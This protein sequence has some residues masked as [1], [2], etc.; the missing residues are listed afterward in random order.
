MSDASITF[1]DR[2]SPPHIATLIIMCSLSALTMN[3]FLPSLPNMTAYFETEYRVM[4][5]SVALYLGVNAALQLFIG[6]LSDQIG[7][8]PVVLG[9]FVLFLLATLGCIFAPNATV[10]LV[11]RMCQ[12]VVSVGLVLS[13]AIIRDIHSQ[14]SAASMIGYVTMGMAVAPMVSPAI[15]GALDAV[16][17]W[18]GSFWLLFVRGEHRSPRGRKTGHR[19]VPVRCG[20]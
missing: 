4:Q 11:F 10:F 7:R 1:L 19:G 17:G 2:R 6:P 15:G 13:R 12:A 5:L 20:N 8:R 3:I 18:Q 9:G 14:D 16:M